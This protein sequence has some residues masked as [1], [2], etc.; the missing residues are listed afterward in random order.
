MQ[1]CKALCEPRWSQARPAVTLAGSG[2]QSPVGSRLVPGEEAEGT[3]PA[4]QF[5]SFQLSGAAAPAESVAAGGPQS[6][7][8][9]A[10]KL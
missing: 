10:P 5:Y 9:M 2:L 1:E 3:P 4:K 8:T 7:L 6:L